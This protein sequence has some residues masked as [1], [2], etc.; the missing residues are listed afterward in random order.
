[1]PGWRRSADRTLHENSLLSGNLTGKFT[2]LAVPKAVLDQESAVLQR[3]FEKFPERINREN[4]SNNR[5]ISEDIRELLPTCIRCVRERMGDEPGCYRDRLKSAKH[6]RVQPDQSF[7]STSLTTRI[8]LSLDC[9]TWGLVCF[10]LSDA[11][12]LPPRSEIEFC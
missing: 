5:E 8:Y 6:D 11:N 10:F 1:M 9:L 7:R 12:Q 3:L 2:F 4:N